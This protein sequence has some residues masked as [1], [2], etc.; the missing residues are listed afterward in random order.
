MLDVEKVTVLVKEVVSD[1]IKIYSIQLKQM[2]KHYLIELVLDNIE[3]KYGSVTIG[4]CEFVSKGLVKLL[5]ENYSDIDFT[6][7][8]S[9]AG[10]ERE[11][12]NLEDY[13]RFKGLLVKLFYKD[14]EGKTNNKIFR[15]T[16]IMNSDIHLEEFKKQSK[17]QENEK[18]CICFDDILRG[19]L[20]INI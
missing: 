6:L 3:N 14:K 12:K 9:S 5:N 18:F 16:D 1:P 17:K 11:L 13:K 20:Y 8:V 19:N 10:A 7:N 4:E 2:G 15:I